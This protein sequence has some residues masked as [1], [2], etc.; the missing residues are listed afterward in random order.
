MLI[1]PLALFNVACLLYVNLDNNDTTKFF[2][3]LAC[4][5]FVSFYLQ[6]VNLSPLLNFFFEK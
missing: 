3:L 6:Y 5:V 2:V 1:F 4:V